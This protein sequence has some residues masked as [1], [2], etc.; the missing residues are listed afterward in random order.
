[1]DR[2]QKGER[3]LILVSIEDRRRPFAG[4]PVGGI[5]KGP[6]GPASMLVNRMPPP[7]KLLPP[8]QRGPPRAPRTLWEDSPTRVKRMGSGSV[9]MICSSFRSL[10]VQVGST[11][12]A[13]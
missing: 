2:Q 1:V 6:P 8:A 13:P 10:L 9:G 11:E 3:S 5:Q 12:M 4:K 7:G